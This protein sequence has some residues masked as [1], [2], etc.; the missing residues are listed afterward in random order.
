MKRFILAGLLL[1]FVVAGVLSH[2]ASR[3]PDGLEKAMA[4]VGAEEGKP[5]LPAPFPDYE[6][7]VLGRILGKT[8]PALVGTA[9]AF[10][11]ILL[12]LR[13]L[14]RRDPHASPPQPGENA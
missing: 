12:L 9:L 13:A 3:S 8:V 10:L 7:P 14:T 4:K 1:S 2:F 11:V 5:A 6:L